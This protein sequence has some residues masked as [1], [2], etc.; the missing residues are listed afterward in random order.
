MELRHLR[1]VVAVA[2]HGSILRAARSLH[3][4][5]S[6]VSEQLADLEQEIAVSLFDRSSRSIRLTPHGELFLIEARK[7][8]EASLHAVEVA[9]GSARGERGH[10][11]IGFFAGG[12]GA[13]LPAVIRSFRRRHPAVRLTLEE[14]Q[15]TTQWQ[16]LRDGRIDLGFTRRLEPP[17][18]DELRSETV[19]HDAVVAVLPRDHP[20]VPA[21]PSSGKV[22]I[23]ELAAES[24]VLSSRET[25]PALFDKIIELCSEAGFSPRIAAFSTVWSSVV[26]LVEAGFGISLLPLNLQQSTA[27]DL[28][29][30]PLTAPN[31]TIELV[32]AWHALR[33]TPALRSLRTLVHAAAARL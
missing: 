24:F 12:I 19:R 27:A 21:P 14:M 20:L 30:C 32:M 7:T 4:A 6:A 18:A 2:E 22:D 11:R 15:P 28:A 3:V 17:F 29:F 16:A 13:G 23:R 9:Q 1:Y 31:A 10:L 26:L 8:L 5:Q 25:S 33:E